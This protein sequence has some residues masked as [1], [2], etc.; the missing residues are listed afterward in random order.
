MRAMWLMLQQPQAEDFVVSTGE[1]HSVREFCECAFTLLGMDYRDYVKEDAD[2]Y[3]RAETIQ[4]VGNS[5]KAHRLLGWK[6]EK[7]FQDLVRM[8]VDAELQVP[9]T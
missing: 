3:R 2:A 9:G 8:M 6:P 4:L 7:G 1:T 5:A